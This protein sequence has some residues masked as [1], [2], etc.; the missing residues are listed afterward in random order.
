MDAMLAARAATLGTEAA[1]EVLARARAL[2]A[3][4]RAVLHFEMGEPDFDTPPHVVE[5][6]AEA[7][8][9]GWTHYVPAAGIPELRAAVAAKVTAERGFPADAAR[10][11]VLPGAKIGIFFTMLAVAG[12]GDEVLVPDPSFPIFESAARYAGAAPVPYRL[13][14]GRGF[15]PDPREIARLLSPRTRLLV[16]NS[17]GNPTGGVAPAADLAAVADAVRAHPRCLVLSDEIYADFVYEGEHRSILAEPGMAERGILLDGFSKS[18]AMTGWRLGYVVAPPPVADHVARLVVNSASCT[19]AFTQRA[20]LAALAGPKEP[21][22]RMVEEFR[23]RRAVMVDGLNSVRGF[24]CASPRGAFYAFPSVEGTGLPAGEVARRLLDEAGVAVVP[25]PA[26]GAA[27]E[28]Y[29]RFS[30]ANTAAN[31]AAAVAKARDL[32]GRA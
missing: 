27:G 23:R 14:E 11:V 8:R 15:S 31:I 12:P 29:V 9:G 19:A 5:A 1:F 20:G 10:V 13:P 4:G 26:F 2:E 24:R 7:L 16:L 25:G 28:G 6:A 17:P 3:Q 30:F 18:F 22:R 21:T 32:F